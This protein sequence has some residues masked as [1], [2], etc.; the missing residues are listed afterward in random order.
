MMIRGTTIK[1]RTFRHLAA[2]IP[3]PALAAILAASG[4]LLAGCSVKE[5]PSL[6]ANDP[7]A[8]NTWIAQAVE[9]DD[10]SACQGLIELLDSSDPA[11]RLVAIGA[12][13]SITGENH[14]FRIADPP[15]LRGQA[16]DRWAAWWLENNPSGNASGPT[17]GADTES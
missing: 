6:T 17:A 10:V 12:L 8:Q 13:R 9:N 3:A 4:L 2:P 14:G 7:L 16:V 5:E 15:A 1:A 11:E